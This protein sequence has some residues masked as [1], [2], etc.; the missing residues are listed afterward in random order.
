ML[1]L[2]LT[3]NFEKKVLYEPAQING[4]NCNHL[5]I[6]TGFTD[7][8][9][10]AQHL[11][12]LHDEQ[13]KKGKYA[14]N[15]SIDIILGMYKGSGITK[16]KHRNI[17]QTLNRINAISNSIH[18]SC[19]YVYKDSEVHSKVYSW[20]R[21]NDPI[22]GYSGSANYTIN[23]FRIR[24]E[25]ISDCSPA[26]ASQYYD[27]LLSDTVDCFD[28]NVPNLLHLSDNQIPDDEISPDNYENLTYDQLIK[29]T[30]IDSLKVSLLGT[31]GKVGETSGP[32]WG[33]RK[34]ESYIDQYGNQIKYNRDRN[35]A[36]IPYNKY[37]QKEGFFPDK[38]NPDDK[39]C[40]LFKTVT[41]DNGIFYMRM[42]QSDNKA[43]QTAESNALLGKWIRERLRVP[44]GAPVTNDDFIRYGKHEVTFYK[45]A[46]D[47]Y[48]MD[49]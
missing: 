14:N 16:R 24:R 49:F 17:M 26:D 34:K 2:F 13:G 3:D 42:A 27:Y 35:Q 9:M 41:K 8:D 30:P 25:V 12:Q 39:N 43:L 33:I 45:Y 19:R 47:V 40:P 48:I 15:I 11:I 6:V 10:I 32:N 37:Q 36:Y 29:K 46:D 28:L 7:C 44:D 5:K 31:G 22:V 23:A 1:K 21:N 38:K 4:D 20:L 18:T